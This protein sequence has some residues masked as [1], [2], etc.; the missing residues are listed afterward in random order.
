MSDYNSRSVGS[1]SGGVSTKPKADRKIAPPPPITKAV[2]LL[3]IGAI[4]TGLR[5]LLNV[6]RAITENRFDLSGFSVGTLL[7]FGGTIGLLAGIAMWVWMAEATA[8]G[9]GWARAVS[10]V[11]AG[12][13]LILL[14]FDFFDVAS[15]GWIGLLLG[16][17]Q[18]AIGVMAVWQMY[19]EQSE[20]YYDACREA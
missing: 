16:I 17:A 1:R 3:R 6:V 7:F 15:I 20:N 10:V 12:F 9:K 14:M 5:L 2:K 19:D 4:V 8:R 13:G 11:M 18:T